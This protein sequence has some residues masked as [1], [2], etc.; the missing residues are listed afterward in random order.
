MELNELIRSMTTYVTKKFLFSSR[1][2]VPAYLVFAFTTLVS[3][4]M[5]AQDTIVD[6]E[7]LSALVE[8]TSGTKAQRHFTFIENNFSGFEPSAGADDKAEHIARLAREWGLDDVTIEKI[9]SDGDQFIQTFKSEPWWEGK[10][11]EVWLTSPNRERIASFG[12][13][14]AHLAR[15]SSNARLQAELVDVGTGTLDEDYAGKDVAGKL[16]L[17]AGGGSAA[18]KKAVWEYG[19]AGVLAYRTINADTYPDQIMVI[20]MTPNKGPDGEPPAFIISLSNRAG[21]SLKKRLEQ[22]ELLKLSVNVEVETRAGHYPMVHALVKGTHPDEPEIWIQ[23]HS[24]YRNSGG[25]N[26]LRTLT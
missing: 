18:H 4:N 11:A 13:H 7:I 23:A 5:V 24:N 25:G 26:N 17:A 9:P 12:E 3:P 20:E 22:G 16:V 10:K 8:E 19:A 2:A 21:M 6:Q 1:I 15:Y 14:R